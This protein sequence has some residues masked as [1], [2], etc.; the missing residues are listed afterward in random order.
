MAPVGVVADTNRFSDDVRLVRACAGGPWPLLVRIFGDVLVRLF[1]MC[2]KVSRITWN[3]HDEKE[4]SVISRPGCTC[5][6][7]E[8][9]TEERLLGLPR[10]PREAV[11][12]SVEDGSEMEC[13]DLLEQEGTAGE[14]EKEEEVTEA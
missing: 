14:E 8:G 10:V 7:L 1:G 5:L 6:S 4:R 9:D 13:V 12:N 3:M 2:V 11:L